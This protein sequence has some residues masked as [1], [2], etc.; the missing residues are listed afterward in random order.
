LLAYLRG[1][2]SVRLLG[3]DNP[4]HRAPTVAVALNE[5]GF[6]V[7]TR[8]AKHGIMAG[9]GH[10]Y[11]YRLLQALGIDPDHGVLRMSFLHYTSPEEIERL[12]AALDAEIA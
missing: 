4:L 3:P 6:A 8:L 11:S 10:F 12:I 2:N 9:G 7:A 1:K 5:P